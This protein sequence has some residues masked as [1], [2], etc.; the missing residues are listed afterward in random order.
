VAEFKIKENLLDNKKLLFEVIK[1][2]LC[3]DAY[4]LSFKTFVIRLLQY[5]LMNISSIP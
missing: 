3:S 4:R 1:Y 2:Q 5:N